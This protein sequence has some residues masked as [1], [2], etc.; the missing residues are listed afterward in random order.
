MRDTRLRRKLIRRL[1]FKRAIDEA[2]QDL[3]DYMF[4]NFE[5][6]SQHGETDY[7]DC[8][9]F[10]FT[11]DYERCEQL[12]TEDEGWLEAWYKFHEEASK[13]YEQSYL[14]YQSRYARYAERARRNLI[15]KKDP[16]PIF[17]IDEDR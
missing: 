10:E 17:S 7:C 12:K 1:S 4:D 11:H 3:S 14:D 5:G 6:E 8:N 2:V 13:E 15:A 9:Y 16:Y